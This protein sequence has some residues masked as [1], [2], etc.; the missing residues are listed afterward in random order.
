MIS[1]WY[2]LLSHPPDFDVLTWSVLTVFPANYLI[3]V[4]AGVGGDVS[5]SP[6]YLYYHPNSVWYLIM[7]FQMYKMKFWIIDFNEKNTLL[8][9]SRSPFKRVGND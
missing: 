7:K 4:L 1:M 8:S 9:L 5:Q 6:V 2:F 3:G